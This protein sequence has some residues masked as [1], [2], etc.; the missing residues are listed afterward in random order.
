MSPSHIRFV[1]APYIAEVGPQ[2]LPTLLTILNFY[3]PNLNGRVIVVM[4]TTILQLI[5]K[6]VSHRE[7]I[8]L[9]V[10]L[11]GQHV[12][13]KLLAKCRDLYALLRSLIERVLTSTTRFA[14]HL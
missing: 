9:F 13:Y 6:L 1:V 2:L 3:H 8:A 5:L 7:N 14:S 10:R 11:N 12:M 4:T